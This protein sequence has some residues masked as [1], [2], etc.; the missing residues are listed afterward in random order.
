VDFDQP[1]YGSNSWDCGYAGNFWSNYTG[2]DMDGDGI[3]DDS[4]VIDLNNVD[5]RPLMNPYVMGDVNYD[6]RID[7]R[8]V[9]FVARRFGLVQTDPLWSAHSDLNEDGIIDM[10]DV[11]ITARKFGQVI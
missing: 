4:H 9:G 2:V 3:G 1:Y 10:R 8:D 11:G 6:G 5:R 7:M